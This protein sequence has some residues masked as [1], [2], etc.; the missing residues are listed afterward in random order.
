MGLDPRPN[1]VMA[2]LTADFPHR[3]DRPTYH[4]AALTTND[5]CLQ[6]RPVP[7][8]GSPDMRGVTAANAFVVLPPGELVHPAGATLEVLAP[9]YVV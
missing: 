3:G 4:P 9:D 1:I 2:T 7:W 8:F 6:V 5:G